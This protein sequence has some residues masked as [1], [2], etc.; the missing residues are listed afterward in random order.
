MSTIHTNVNALA[1][2]Q[3]VNSAARSIDA[4]QERISTGLKA[5]G[6]KVQPAAFGI[7]Q[8]QRAELGSLDAVITGLNRASSIADVALATG[9]AISDL[10]TTMRS[11]AVAAADPSMTQVSRTIVNRDFIEL[12]DQVQ[13]MIANAQF[14]GVGILGGPVG[15][16]VTFLDSTNGSRTIAL[17]NLD[18]LLP[19]APGAVTSPAAAMYVGSGSTILTA[20][21]AVDMSARVT[22]TLDFVNVE[23]TKLGAAAKRVESQTVYFSKIKDGVTSGIGNIV[24][25]DLA[26]ESAMLEALK[27]RKE[28]SVTSVSMSSQSTQALLNLLRTN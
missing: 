22:A 12:R 28:L 27:V 5:T 13:T 20:L 1:A 9:S 11:F 7:A 2:V 19:A 25:A 26:K 6:G 4:V 15:T 21:D 18:F 14:D 24:D 23:L 8:N 3:S 16:S 10:L 17:P